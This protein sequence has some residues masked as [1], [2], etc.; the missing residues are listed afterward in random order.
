[1]FPLRY[2]DD[3]MRLCYRIL[4]TT[5]TVLDMDAWCE[6]L[7]SRGHRRFLIV[8]VGFRMASYDY[9]ITNYG[10]PNLQRAPYWCVPTRKAHRILMHSVVFAGRYR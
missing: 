9:L 8:T 10:N 4:E 5:V 3:E 7:A 1:M 2:G 6:P